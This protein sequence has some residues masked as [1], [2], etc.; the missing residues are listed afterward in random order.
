MT[1]ERAYALRRSL[2]RFQAADRKLANGDGSRPG[3]GFD[4]EEAMAEAADEY[5]EA[6]LE[7]RREMDAA[8]HAAAKAGRP[9]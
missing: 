9:L 1:F 5:I 4:T 7:H 2:Q 6:A 3:G 8:L